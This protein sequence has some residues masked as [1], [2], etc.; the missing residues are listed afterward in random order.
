MLAPDYGDLYILIA[1]C[2]KDQHNLFLLA[3]G[4]GFFVANLMAQKFM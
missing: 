1:E 2:L 4:S 3:K